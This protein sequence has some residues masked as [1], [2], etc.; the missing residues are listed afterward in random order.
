MIACSYETQ[1]GKQAKYLIIL[2]NFLK[3]TVAKYVFIWPPYM[4]VNLLFN[5]HGCEVLK[6][7][8]LIIQEY[9]LM[10]CSTVSTYQMHFFFRI[11]EVNSIY[12]I[13]GLLVCN[14]NL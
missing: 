3:V 8:F 9:Y 6:P 4:Y 12:S 1:V 2:N 10:L 7:P 5:V 11:N 14:S 13:G